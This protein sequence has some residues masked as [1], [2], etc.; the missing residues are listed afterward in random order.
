[1]I[2]TNRRTFAAGI[3]ALAAS[4]IIPASIF[5]QDDADQEESAELLAQIPGL[6]SAYARRYDRADSHSHIEIDDKPIEIS[7]KTPDRFVINALEFGSAA[8]LTGILGMMLNTDTAGLLMSDQGIELTQE[9]AGDFPRGST[10]FYGTSDDGEYKSLLVV[11]VDN[12]GFAVTTTGASDAVQETADAVAAFLVD[13]EPSDAPV[14]VVSEGVAQGGV[15]DV[16]P[17]VDDLEMLNGLIPMYDYDL[18][19][20][21]SPILPTDASPAASPAS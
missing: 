17:G 11:P 7:E 14:V 4:A 10:I 5:A 16:F 2:R 13:Q 3:A 1:M 21:E 6:K 12:I 15:F 18:L 9:P 8:E 19:V 20:S